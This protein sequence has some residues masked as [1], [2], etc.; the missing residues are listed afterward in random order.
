MDASPGE[1]TQVAKMMGAFRSHL[2][3]QS[4]ASSSSRSGSLL[5]VRSEAGKRSLATR[6]SFDDTLETSRIEQKVPRLGVDPFSSA[7]GIKRFPSE[8]KSQ[9]VELQKEN[10]ELKK[11]MREVETELVN[12]KALAAKLEHRI[13]QVELEKKKK[14]LEF[15]SHLERSERHRKMEKEKSDNLQ[16]QLKQ[17][18]KEEG[19]RLED[20][21]LE[22]RKELEKRGELERKNRQ[23]WE[24]NR[25]V[26]IQL[27]E[28]KNRMEQRPDVD[29][30]SYHRQVQ[31]WEKK[32]S[33]VEQELES[34]RVET[35]ALESRNKEA[36]ELRKEMEEKKEEATRLKLRVGRLEA[37]LE[38]NR[39]AVLQRK[40]MKDKLEKFND[41]EKENVHLRN[42]NRLLVETQ[43]NTALMKEKLNNLQ[44]QLET[45]EGSTREAGRLAAELEVAQQQL[46]GWREM[47]RQ[48]LTVEEREGGVG[49]EV[50]RDVFGKRQRKEASL[51]DDRARLRVEVETLT[52]RLKEAEEDRTKIGEEVERLRR[53][54]EEQTRLVKR[55]QRKL[56]LVTK[57]RDG[58]KGV[59]DSYEKEVTLSG[60]QLDKERVEA[61]EKTIEEYKKVVEKLEEGVGGAVDGRKVEELQEKIRVLEKR[62]EELQA[63]VERGSIRGSIV[64]PDTKILH[65]RSN[66]ASQAGERRQR[67]LAETREENE[68]L[69]ARVKLLEEG[70]TKDLTMLVGHK[71]EEGASSE[72]VEKLKDQLQS[73]SVKNQRMM[74]AFK[75]TSLD[76]RE[77]VYHLTGYRID[78]YGDNQY[79]IL[80]MY[81]D[82]KQDHLLFKKSASGEIQMLE[83]AF[84]GQLTELI[85]VHLNRQGSIPRFLA[86]LISNLFDKQGIEDREEEEESEEEEE[87]DDEEEE[88]DEAGSDGSDV[89]CIE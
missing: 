50:V 28:M 60:S 29:K 89:V 47:A 2:D 36:V 75:K 58:Y 81:A 15:D 59:L 32:L 86:A 8:N 25:K 46:E 43:E 61:L 87:D 18:R 7:A 82:S 38:A 39:D 83:S 69:R 67:E 51:V 74:E 31:A 4:A 52:R 79:R 42:T 72:E 73:A 78:G 27:E 76:F 23:L 85:D 19:R 65:L 68:A 12:S 17:I 56:L 33:E 6:L 77:L 53:S 20:K 35:E 5:A 24:D 22:G 55:L 54:Q 80:P 62:N 44:R 30:R 71:I 41:L 21:G 10:S 48:F 45:A 84:S 3:Q 70:Q 49:V 66:P 16:F 88:E 34:K 9:A 13:G 26:T 11:K 14:A 64:A 57:E 63:E 1:P 37:E 40:V